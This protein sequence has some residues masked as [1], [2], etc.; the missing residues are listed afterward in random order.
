MRIVKV[1]CD[2]CGSQGN[3]FTWTYANCLGQ[4]A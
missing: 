2:R 1:M 4:R 3:V